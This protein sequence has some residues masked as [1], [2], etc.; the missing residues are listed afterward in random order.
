MPHHERQ[1]TDNAGDRAAA[2]GSPEVC[3]LVLSAESATTSAARAA[4]A[5]RKQDVAE[6]VDRQ[7]PPVL[8]ES[9]RND[10][11]E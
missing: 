11:D 9:A 7:W 10:V 4:A 3:V 5:E 2:E 8:V 1:S 6:R